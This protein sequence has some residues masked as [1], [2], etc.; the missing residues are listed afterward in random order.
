MQIILSKKKQILFDDFE[1]HFS[2]FDYINWE[3]TG[4][5]TSKYFPEAAVN[6]LKPGG[7]IVLIFL[8]DE[9][10]GIVYSRDLKVS[11]FESKAESTPYK[12]FYM[13]K[14]SDAEKKKLA[15]FYFEKVR[16]N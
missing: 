11:Y 9:L 7:R 6:T 5:F 10:A 2:K 4:E 1:K 3:G 14:M 16:S 13:K 8:H 15:E 12:I